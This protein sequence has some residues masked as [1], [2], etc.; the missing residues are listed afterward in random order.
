MAPKNRSKKKKNVVPASKKKSRTRNSTLRGA[1][2]IPAWLNAIRDPWSHGP[3]SVPDESCQPSL[4]YES[5]FTNSFLTSDTSATPGV[6]HGLLIGI[7]PYLFG[8]NSIP[9]AGA[10]ATR[11][12]DSSANSFTGNISTSFMPNQGAMFPPVTI[13]AGSPSV[14]YTYRMT[15]LSAK[16]TY[17]GTE[18]L[19]GGRITAGLASP[20]SSPI[21]RATTA[22]SP[23]P[24]NMVYS[25]TSTTLPTQAKQSIR[26]RLRRIATVRNPD[27][28]TQ[29]TWVPTGVPKYAPLIQDNTS[30]INP[31]L[32]NLGPCIF[33]LI[34]DDATSVP[35]AI[36]NSYQLDVVMHVEVIPL[37]RYALAVGP[38]PSPYDPSAL[39]VCL[40][41]FEMMSTVSEWDSGLHTWIP[42]GAQASVPSAWESAA[43]IGNSLLGSTR[44]ALDGAAQ[45]MSHP[46]TR[47]IAALA[48][49]S[50]RGH[51]G[52][53]QR[54]L[55]Y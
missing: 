40:N 48:A 9:G 3:T 47:Q 38:T 8:P 11:G 29:V 27:G 37:S 28:S 23:N 12:F 14:A 15:A 20:E 4:K 46:L 21:V 6:N 19:R 17:M 35:S 32:E 55:M 2:K 54:L 41:A 31:Y 13:N 25:Y 26:N 44:Y 24:I 30:T 18:L 1:P 43:S 36:G 16:I 34:D 39:S 22:Q 33:F 10:I 52:G 7:G 45:V 49:N 5:R 51:G 50:R 53:A 42:D